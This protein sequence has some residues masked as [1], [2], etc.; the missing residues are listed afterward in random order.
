M[1]SLGIYAFSVG[2]N[3]QAGVMPREKKIAPK[4]HQ[5]RTKSAPKVNLV[6]AV[7]V[8]NRRED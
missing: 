2:Q 8:C 1:R 3:P 6:R 5:K 4:A 7:G